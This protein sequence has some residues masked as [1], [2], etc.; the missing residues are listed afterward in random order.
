MTK[1]Y[2]SLLPS[3]ENETSSSLFEG[4]KCLACM[5]GMSGS[6]LLGGRPSNE[7]YFKTWTWCVCRLV[8]VL[9]FDFLRYN[10]LAFCPLH[11]F[12][13]VTRHKGNTDCSV[14]AKIVYFYDKSMKLCQIIT[15]P[16]TS[17]FGYGA[18]PNSPINT[19]TAQALKMANMKTSLPLEILL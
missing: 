1:D 4:H 17:I 14:S 15:K 9:S 18:N 8:T 11:D 16:K 5:N 13:M 12:S 19:S 2:N 10:C 6:F 3:R 7:K